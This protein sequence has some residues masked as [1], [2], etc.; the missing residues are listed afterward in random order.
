MAGPSNGNPVGLYATWVHEAIHSTGHSSRLGRDPYGGMGEAGEG[1]R[2]YARV[3]LVTELEAVL[4]GDLL[5][6]GSSIVNQ[7]VDLIWPE[8]VEA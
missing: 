5:E 8:A 7:A 2:C 1:G 6:S 3:E 4:L